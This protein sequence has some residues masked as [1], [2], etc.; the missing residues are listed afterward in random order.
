MKAIGHKKILS[1]GLVYGAGPKVLG[2]AILDEVFAVYA[3]LGRLLAG[4]LVLS[5]SLWIEKVLVAYLL[6]LTLT[7]AL[8][9]QNINTLRFLLIGIFLF[10]HNPRA[11]FHIKSLIVGAKV[12]LV[13][14]FAIVL[15][16]YSLNLPAAFWQDSFW[17]GTAY[18][19]VFSCFAA[20]LCML[21]ARH[22]LTTALILFLYLS[23]AL[24][25]DSR[26]QLILTV[27][28]VPTILAGVP[29]ERAARINYRRVLRASM[30]FVVTS[31]VVSVTFGISSANPFESVGPT[32]RAFAIGDDERDADRKNSINASLNWAADHPVKVITGSGFLVHQ[33]ALARYYPPSSYGDGRVRPVGVSAL[34]V[35]GGIILSALILLNALMTLLYIRRAR[36]SVFLKLST[37]LVLVVVLSSLIIT[38]L[39]DAVLFWLI[40]MPS[41]VLPSVLQEWSPRSLPT[42]V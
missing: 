14:Y 41:G 7:G 28:L 26:L 1:F 39:F 24:L 15:V 4:R 2:V 8:A 3:L 31:L 22:L 13:S 37:T 16:G 29:R 40:I 5:N 34:I 19:A 33:M 17:T 27:V 30:L 10:F 38:N 36:V 6:L 20:W 18:A 23:I 12:F 25:A 35:D 9:T 32:L 11:T 21:F 42:S